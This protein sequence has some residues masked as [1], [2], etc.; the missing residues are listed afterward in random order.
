MRRVLF[1]WRG[2]RLYAYPAMLYLGLV[3]GVI[4][5]TYAATL[6]GLDPAPIYATML[7]L[8]LPALLGARLLFVASNW[9]LYR[10]E[11]RRIWRRAD[12]GAALYGGLIVSFL[13]SLPL[14]RV[15]GISVG[16]FWD[17]TI[18]TMLIG[19]IF[20]KVGCLLHG[21]CGG[22]RTESR[23]GLY[24]PN[25]HRVWCRRIPAQLLEAGLAVV[26]LIGSLHAWNRLPF[27]GA[28][29]LSVVAGYGVGRWW[30][31]SIRES[32]DMV[33]SMS[34]HRMISAALVT[35]STACLVV[36]WFHNS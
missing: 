30:L 19:M 29:F 33:G 27:A 1:E 16:A 24:S 5:G 18:I 12:G 34:V 22:R 13:L 23:L 2:A 8:I 11:P 9:R 4:G 10:R 25:E 31:E 17:A 6:H 28:C 3:F 21:C 35:L 14:L 20:T 26:L 36:L 15:Q 32:I 7:L